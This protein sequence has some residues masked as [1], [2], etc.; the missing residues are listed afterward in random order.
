MHRLTW[1]FCSFSSFT[2]FRPAANS[3][4][5]EDQSVVEGVSKPPASKNHA[6]ELKAATSPKCPGRSPPSSHKYHKQ[7]DPDHPHHRDGHGR[8]PRVYKWS[9]QMCK[10]SFLSQSP[11][12]LDSFESFM[13]I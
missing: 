5:S 9:F 6:P 1:L 3:S 10:C 2:V 7:G 12:Q 11:K 8:L 13:L 4:D